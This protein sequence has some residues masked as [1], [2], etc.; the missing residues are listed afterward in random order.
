MLDHLLQDN[1][2]SMVEHLHQDNFLSMVVRLPIIMATAKSSHRA[3]SIMGLGL[4]ILCLLVL[5]LLFRMNQVRTKTHLSEM[6][7]NF[8]MFSVS[9]DV[10]G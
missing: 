4:M 9:F 3:L 7:P 2:L 5:L 6:Y 10:L 8:L 1:F